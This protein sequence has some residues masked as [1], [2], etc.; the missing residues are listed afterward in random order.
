MYSKLLSKHTKSFRQWN[1]VSQKLPKLPKLSKEYICQSDPSVFKF[2]WNLKPA[3]Q[4]YFDKMLLRKKVSKSLL[5]MHLSSHF[6]IT[7]HV[8]FPGSIFCLLLLINCLSSSHYL[9]SFCSVKLGHFLVY[10]KIFN[11]ISMLITS[12][13]F[14]LIGLCTT[15]WYLHTWDEKSF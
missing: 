3:T 15:K 8:F 13:S 10:V 1:S 12:Q 4:W 7:E 6:Y 5:C 11:G 9:L 14:L 2:H